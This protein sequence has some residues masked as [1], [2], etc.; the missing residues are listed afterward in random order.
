MARMMLVT[1]ARAF[2]MCHFS[3]RLDT[4]KS[5][6][7]ISKEMAIGS[8]TLLAKISNARISAHK[9]AREV[10]LYISRVF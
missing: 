5:K 2:F 4:G 3:R 8:N 6:N 9:I 7:V 10:A 1:I